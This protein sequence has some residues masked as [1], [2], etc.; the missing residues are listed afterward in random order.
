MG[1]RLAAFLMVAAVAVLATLIAAPDWPGLF[2][3]V[4][5]LVGAAGEDRGAASSDR[6]RKLVLPPDGWVNS[7]PLS[8]GTQDDPFAVVVFADTH[9]Y[10]R[11]V[12]DAA[13]SWHEAYTRFDLEVVGVHSP[14]FSFATGPA[15]ARRVVDRFALTFPVVH[16]PSLATLGGLGSNAADPQVVL[17]ARDGTIR[18][19]WTVSSPAEL[20]PLENAVRDLVRASNPDRT[21]PGAPGGSPPVEA[22]GGTLRRVRL[23]VPSVR[24]GPLA[25]AEM[26]RAQP[27]TAAFRHEI[28]G[29]LWVPHPVG[30]WT[31]GAEGLTAVRGGAANFLAIRY[32]APRVGLVAAPAEGAESRVY[33]LL[34]EKWVPPALTGPDV[35]FDGDGASYV[36]VDE[37]RLYR[38]L[39]T[40]GRHVLKLSPRDAGT[41]FHTLTFE[42]D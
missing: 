10:A 39:N 20:A 25:G 7:A 27:F 42:F 36:L 23:G 33:M 29:A 18:S 35:R 16:D 34:D 32:D 15:Y 2:S 17:V 26:G 38:I 40:S 9:P 5:E 28:E 11:L 12:L 8:I 1:R 30:W 21:F 41:T 6:E 37:P 3:R 4:R 19:L 31:P 14:E 22:D 24:E 13:R